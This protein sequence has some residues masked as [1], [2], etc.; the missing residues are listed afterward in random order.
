MLCK[1]ISIYYFIG[2]IE[3]EKVFYTIAMQKKRK[4]NLPYEFTTL[5]VL[6]F[7]YAGQGLA[8]LQLLIEPIKATTVRRIRIF[9]ICVELG[10]QQLM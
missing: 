8:D 2:A 4:A 9:F 10:Y 3:Q 7:E 5:S 6:T 1:D